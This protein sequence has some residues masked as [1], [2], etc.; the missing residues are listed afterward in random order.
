MFEWIEVMS[1]TVTSSRAWKAGISILAGAV[2]TLLLAVFVAALFPVLPL[3]KLMPWFIAFNAA[4]SG[5]MLLDKT[6]DRLNHKRLFAVGAGVG[7]VVLVCLAWFFLLPFFT[8]LVPL[9]WQDLLLWFGAGICCSGLGG[10]LAVKY[11]Q[12]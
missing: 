7:V 10:I 2:G 8:G 6:R 12:L 11:F 1:F 3:T 5:Y 9:S 4:L